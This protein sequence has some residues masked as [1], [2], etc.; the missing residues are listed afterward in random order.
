MRWNQAGYVLAAMLLLAAPSVQAQG[1]PLD[2]PQMRQMIR[3]FWNPVVGSG[4]AYQSTGD[5]DSPEKGV[6]L[7]LIGKEMVQGKQGYW[8]E[9]AFNSPELGGVLYAKDLI[10]PEEG[11]PRKV[12]FQLPGEAPMEMPVNSNPGPRKVSDTHMHKVGTETITVP[13][14][15]FACEHWKDDDGDYWTSSKVS[16][17]T[18]VKSVSKSSTDVLTK[19]TSGAKSHITGAVK[20]WDPSVFM[21]HMKQPGGN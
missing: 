6:E 18:L 3:R 11:S 8:L 21:R 7:A 13:A 17:V 5:P 10:V 12:I 2:T 1:N 16:P 15:T 20:P 9:L 19:V 4:E 14:G